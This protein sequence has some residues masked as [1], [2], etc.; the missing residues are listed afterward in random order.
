MKFRY[1]IISLALSLTSVA[2]TA[3]DDDDDPAYPNPQPIEDNS[4]SK[5]LK[6]GVETLNV[7]IGTENRQEVAVADGNGEYSAFSSNSNIAKAYTD[8]GKI[9]VE[10][11]ANGKTEVIVTDAASHYAKLPVSIY[12]T[13]VMQLDVTTM[14]FKHLVGETRTKSGKVTLGNGEYTIESDNENVTATID[15][16]SGEFSVTAKATNEVYTA[17]VTVSDCTGI[18]ATV[19]VTVDWTDDPFDDALIESVLSKTPYVY[20]LSYC[21]T[22]YSR[23][24]SLANA[25]QADDTFMYGWDYWGYYYMKV[26]SPSQEEGTYDNCK[27]EFSPT[28]NSSFSRSITN[29]TVRIIKNEDKMLWILFKYTYNG[30]IEYGYMVTTVI[31]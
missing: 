30:A 31:D 17:T 6:L 24:G 9:Y 22:S 25:K 21:D 18:S 12:T 15:F 11:V 5:P 2:F 19:A 4:T 8:G 28:W 1:Y 7:K 26:Y 16:D 14:E 3:C 23:Y 10:G 29:A 13:E 27:V 20:Y